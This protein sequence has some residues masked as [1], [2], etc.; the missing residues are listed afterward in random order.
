MDGKLYYE[1]NK[2]KGTIVAWKDDLAFE[3][4]EKIINENMISKSGF[5][6]FNDFEPEEKTLFTFILMNSCIIPDKIVVKTR[7]HGDDVWDEEKGIKIARTKWRRKYNHECRKAMTA[8]RK[9]LTALARK[10]IEMENEY[11][12]RAFSYEQEYNS[13]RKEEN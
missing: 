11:G 5:T 9:Q 1:V 6:E 3:V 12:D 4:I 13:Y 10:V 7:L 8:F 2:D